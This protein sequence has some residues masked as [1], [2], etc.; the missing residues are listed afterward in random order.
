MK[1][2]AFLFCNKHGEISL[3]IKNIWNSNDKKFKQSSCKIFTRMLITKDLK[4]SAYLL[5]FNSIK[6]ISSM[7]EK[8]RYKK[9][10]ETIT[11]IRMKFNIVD[12]DFEKETFYIGL[13]NT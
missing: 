12:T 3:R 1:I 4:I 9:C 2:Y 7:N 5:T 6:H 10:T 8:S 13:I 11:T